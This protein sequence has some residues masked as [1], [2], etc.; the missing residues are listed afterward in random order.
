VTLRRRRRDGRDITCREA[1]SLITEYLEDALERND[2]A[3]LEAH[4]AECDP[5]T[6]HLRQIRITIATTGRVR[7]EELDPLAREDLMALYRRWQNDG[8]V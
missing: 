2:R 1:V 5:C 7:E 8:N 3:R 6:E 4:L